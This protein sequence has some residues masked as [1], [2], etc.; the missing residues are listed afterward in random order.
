MSRLGEVIPREDG[1]DRGIRILGGLIRICI[2]AEELASDCFAR[3]QDQSLHRPAYRFLSTNTYQY[4]AEL[5]D[6]LTGCAWAISVYRAKCDECCA[7]AVQLCSRDSYSRPV[8][9]ALSDEVSSIFRSPWP[10]HVI[11]LCAFLT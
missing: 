2:Q 5:K 9:Q 8:R 4:G 7:E 10:A 6:K 3:R 11:Q 1:P